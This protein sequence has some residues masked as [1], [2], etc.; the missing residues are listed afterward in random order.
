MLFEQPINPS[1]AP[2]KERGNATIIVRG[3]RKLLYS[4]DG[5]DTHQCQSQSSSKATENLIHNLSITSV[6]ARFGR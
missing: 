4:Y 1:N 2:P 6:A 3:W 5:I